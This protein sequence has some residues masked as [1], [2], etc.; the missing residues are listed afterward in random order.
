MKF[1]VKSD[2]LKEDHGD[3]KEY[4]TEYKPVAKTNTIVIA[5]VLQE[6]KNNNPDPINQIT[7]I[8]SICIQNTAASANTFKVVKATVTKSDSTTNDVVPAGDGWNATVTK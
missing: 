5:D 7:K 8:A 2:A 4:Y 6:I 1:A 3:W